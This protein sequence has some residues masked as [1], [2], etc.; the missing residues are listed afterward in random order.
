MSFEEYRNNMLKFVNL[1]LHSDKKYD[2]NFVE[3]IQNKII[4]LK[5]KYPE[6]EI[7]Y[8]RWCWKDLDKA[9]YP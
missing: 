3:K 1:L 6:L 8:R 5:E 9:F 2:K 7:Q 4:K